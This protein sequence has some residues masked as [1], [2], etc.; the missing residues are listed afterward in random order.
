LPA[1]RR[2]R[3]LAPSLASV[4]ALAVLAAPAH[5]AQVSGRVVAGDRP[6]EGARV[7]LY[8]SG[9]AS[10]SR[11]GSATSDERGRFTVSYSPRRGAVVYAVA[12]GGSTRARRAL[13]MMAVGGGSPRRLAINEL[14]TVAAA[15]SLSR[16][17]RGVAISGP[18]T[19]LGNAAATVPSL[20]RRATGRVAKAVAD[21]PNGTETA[22][23]ATFRTLAAI[24]GGC[25]RGTRRDCR[26]LFAAATPPGE[27]RPTDTLEA[28]HDIALNPVNNVRRISR[29]RQSRAYRPTLQRPPSSWVLSLKHT[30]AA[31][32]GPGRM[33]FDSKG[34]IW[35]TNNFQPP[36]TEAG[37]YAIALDPTGR[38]RTAGPFDGGSLT[39]GGIQGNWWGIA[40][41]GRDRVWLSN[42]T[43]DDPNEFYS[44]DFKGGNAAS[45]F[46]ADGVA[47]SGDAGITAGPLQAPQGIAVDADDNVWIANHGND[48]VTLYPKGDPARARVISAGRRLYNP[49]TIVTDASA[50]AW[51]NNGSLDASAVGSVT[52]IAP[53]GTLTGPFPVNAMRS[54]QG[55]AIDSAG[56]LW[57]ASLVDSS[58]TRLAPDGTVKG[59]FRAPS[60]EGPWGVAVDGDDNVWVA[61]FLGEKVTKL[62]GRN[63]AR[64]PRGTRT[65]EAISPRLHGFTNGGLQHLT[66]VQVDQSGNVWVANNWAKIAPTVG[67]DGLVEFIGAAAPVVTPL[68]GP[69][70]R[71]R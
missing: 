15:Y 9:A 33:A 53:D 23:L 11:L 26:R 67:G 62:C 58:V 16:F 18:S 25:T 8:A 35:V 55:M 3:R 41:D 38:P 63:P 27:P 6:V 56:D 54:P 2:A 40:V 1:P 65:G 45:L 60:I 19:G 37:L 7:T 42:F 14:T 22:T 47:L 71:P 29:L 31:Y 20:V 64:C 59:Q 57:I 13:R 49:F 34:N 32:D 51:V 50:N 46:T 12:S 21:P 69:P 43:G 4:A 68:I 10:A 44:P 52:R 61:S 28:I 70:A 48:T 24:V 5:G 30:D 36:G 39:G 17:L 66:A